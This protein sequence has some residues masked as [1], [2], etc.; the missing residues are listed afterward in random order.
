MISSPWFEKRLPAALLASLA[1]LLLVTLVRTRLWAEPTFAGVEDILLTALVAGVASL[2]P[3]VLFRMG[4]ALSMAWFFGVLAA[5]HLGLAAIFA[6]LLLATSAWCLGR[7]LLPESD[8]P[9]S[10][11]VVVGLGL[12][13]GVLGWLVPYAIHYRATHLLL[14]LVPVFWQWAAVTE[15]IR[16][17]WTRARNPV[18]TTDRTT[19]FS[20]WFAVL[21]IGLMGLPA[22]LPSA[23]PD[24]L[25]YHLGLPSEFLHHGYYR[26]DAATTIWANA[27]WATDV[28]QGVVA[29]LIGSIESRGALHVLWYLLALALFWQLL[30]Q[31]G[32]ALHMRWLV[33]ALFASQ[34]LHWQ[35]AF[36]M[37]TEMPTQAMLL[38]LILLIGDVTPQ[39]SIRRLLAIASVVGLLLATKILSLAYLVPLAVWFFWRWRS[40]QVQ[41]LLAPAAL[42]LVIAGAS[43]TYS[44]L[45]SGNPLLPLFNHVFQSP[46]YLPIAFR[47]AVYGAG[48]DWRLPWRLTV[49]SHQFTEGYAGAG[50]WQWPFVFVLLPWLLLH[51]VARRYALIGLV[52]TVMVWININHLRYSLPAMLPLLLALGIW[53]RP[54]QR[55]AQW[56]L[57]VLCVGNVLYAQNSN[58]MLRNGFIV[59]YLMKPEGQARFLYDRRPERVIVARLVAQQK[60]FLLFQQGTDAPLA[61]LGGR[62]LSGNW[63]DPESQFAFA[64]AV[65][66]GPEAVREFLQSRGVS[67]VLLDERTVVPAFLEALDDFA[68]ITDTLGF[69]RLYAVPD[70][71]ATPTEVTTDYGYSFQ[72]DKPEAGKPHVLEIKLT[73]KC[74]GASEHF[75]LL[76]AAIGDR[77]EELI[78]DKRCR[79]QETIHLHRS[80]RLKGPFQNAAISLTSNHGPADG[81]TLE[82]REFSW[83]RDLM[84]ERDFA[85]RMRGRTP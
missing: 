10:L 59:E 19:R 45:V 46:L 48:L 52:G 20:M 34:P 77:P 42:M 6:V 7:F 4:W 38:A 24:D 36:G 57:V 29:V 18:A 3:K 40:W 80:L 47:D 67:H 76:R 37:Q 85:R 63:S 81:W 43:Y 22:L 44:Y 49:D 39:T 61:E 28:A 64:E 16:T 35:L 14:L 21:V 2:V 56:A 5:V 8:T 65:P 58:Y 11:K 62:G 32:V 78:G 30:T 41:R 31:H 79:G 68:A 13:L 73:V 27:P 53:L 12:L 84:A 55:W 51:P 17:W 75:V 33:T 72:F 54:G 23:M 25:A 71:V 9:E 50:G 66:K 82:H 74:Q 83:R 60:P 15:V 69:L 26:L 1:V 70:R